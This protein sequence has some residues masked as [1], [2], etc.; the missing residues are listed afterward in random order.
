MTGDP[1]AG[2][3]LDTSALVKLFVPERHSDAVRAGYAEAAVTF[4]SQL[5]LVESHATFA[6]MHA[7]RRLDD[8]G[9]D[10]V[11]DAFR[12]FWS[13]V[14]VVPVDASLVAAGAV[15][16]GRHALRGYDAMQLAAA[17]EAA[18]TTPVVFGCFD[19]DL[20]VA[21]TREGLPLLPR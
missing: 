2:L 17:L 21:A 19:A 4:A 6:R 12:R 5:A 10:R 20:E 11:L 3:F 18:S 1:T 9:R 7:G 15:L 8:T 13:D 16:A 14:A